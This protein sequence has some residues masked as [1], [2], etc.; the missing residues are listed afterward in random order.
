MK[1]FFVGSALALA[2]A[3]AVLVGGASR[4]AGD[5]GPPCSNITGA[6]VNYRLVAGT[7]NTYSFAADLRLADETRSAPIC[8]N[9]VYTLYIITD[10]TN[11][12]ATPIQLGPQSSDLFGPTSFTDSNNVIC[13]YATSTLLSSKT[14]EPVTVFD[15][16]PNSGCASLTASGVGGEIG[17]N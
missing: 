12:N 13:I 9:V 6:T 5:G 11:P 14:G 2:A 15:R 3:A 16:A 4:A 8:A 7:S 17:F 1:R 10:E